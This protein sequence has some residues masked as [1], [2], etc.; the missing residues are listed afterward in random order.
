MSYKLFYLFVLSILCVNIA[1]QDFVASLYFEDNKGKKDT[2]EFGSLIGARN[3]ID[4]NF[5]E[6]DILDQPLDSFDVR[7]LSYASGNPN[8]PILLVAECDH[9]DN[10]IFFGEPFMQHGVKYESKKSFLNIGNCIPNGGGSLFEFFIAKNAAY[11]ITISWDSDLFQDTCWSNTLISE[12]PIFLD[13]TWC[14]ERINYP[15]TLLSKSNSVTIDE[16]NFVTFTREDSTIVSMYYL[17]LPNSSRP[18]ILTNVSNEI[19]KI[20]IDLYP[21]PVQDRLTLDTDKNNFNYTIMN[22]QGQQ[23]LQ[24]EYREFIEVST[25]ESGIYFIQIQDKDN[26]YQAQKFVKL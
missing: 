24:G 14:E 5:G 12:I 23:V 15:R 26:L 16:P 8:A 4:T 19:E 18:L 20:D 13:T 21:N 2:L 7:F 1:A 17:F 25:L 22:T 6:I 11:P 9:E 10:D 3:C